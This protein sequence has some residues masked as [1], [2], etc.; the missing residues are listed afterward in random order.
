MKEY[1]PTSCPRDK[2][3]SNTSNA[4]DIEHSYIVIEEKDN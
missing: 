3:T 4:S 2:A 1:N